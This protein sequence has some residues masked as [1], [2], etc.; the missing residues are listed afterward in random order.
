MEQELA[1]RKCYAALWSFK[2]LKANSE[3]L[4]IEQRWSCIL[5]KAVE[6]F[7][8]GGRRLS[9]YYEVSLFSER[10]SCRLC[11]KR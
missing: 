6:Q 11:V 3:Q 8:G 5:S 1:L 7:R 10:D 2:E 4:K 9:V